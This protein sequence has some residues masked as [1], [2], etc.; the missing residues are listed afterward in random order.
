MRTHNLQSVCQRPV[1]L[2]IHSYI[3]LPSAHVPPFA[4]HEGVNAIPV[5][6]TLLSRPPPPPSLRRR[7][8]CEE[9][10]KCNKGENFA[11][12]SASKVISR[13][14]FG[15]ERERGKKNPPRWV[16]PFRLARRWQT[17]I[18]HTEDWPLFCWTA[19][20]VL[21]EKLFLTIIALCLLID[22]K[23]LYTYG[24]F[25][26]LQDN[27]T[28]FIGYVIHMLGCH[29]HLVSQTSTLFIITIIMIQ[30]FFID[31]A[32]PYMYCTRKWGIWTVCGYLCG[33]RKSR[34]PDKLLNV[35]SVFVCSAFHSDGLF[36]ELLW[37][38]SGILALCVS[39]SFFLY[40]LQWILLGFFN[41]IGATVL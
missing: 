30:A 19:V 1:F 15:R 40:Y 6:P 8:N 11:F 36:T 5:D 32:T 29:F 25:V 33:V 9:G 28:S 37:I 21:G 38:Q 4:G 39:F 23:G 35:L 16:A 3:R 12:K 41:Q 20:S 27:L 18:F 34:Q 13:P 24:Y 2:V 10:F 17:G 22:E 31:C 14:L 7:Q 26:H